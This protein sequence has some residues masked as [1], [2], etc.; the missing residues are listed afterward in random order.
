VTFFRQVV[1]KNS[2]NIIEIFH[3]VD[4]VDLVFR[5]INVLPRCAQTSMGKEMC[6]EKCEDAVFETAPELQPHRML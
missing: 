1:S 5:Y 6:G 4:T 2:D 3:L